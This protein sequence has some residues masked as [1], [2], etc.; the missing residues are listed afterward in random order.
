M[1]LLA[2]A[3][4][5]I[6]T[7]STGTAYLEIALQMVVLGTGMGLT[8]APAT[9]SIMGAVSDAKAGIG[10]AVNDTTRELGAT[11]GVAVIGSVFASLYDDAVSGAATRGLPDAALGPAQ[12][13]IGAALIAA[14]R[15]ADAGATEAAATLAGVASAGFFDG[16]QAGC[17]VAAAVCLAGALVCFA[18][19]PAHP[20]EASS[21]MA[22]PPPSDPGPAEPETVRAPAGSGAA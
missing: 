18:I 5:W 10:S 13:S 20:V 1:L 21:A 14:G 17:L 2:T 15:L 4:A 12:D 7:A 9:E 6:S 8:S 22:D 3:Y 19:L 16:M 11:L